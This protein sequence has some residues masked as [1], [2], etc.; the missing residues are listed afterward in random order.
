[1]LLGCVADD[2]TGASDLANALVKGGM[3]SIQFVGVPSGEAP[4]DC[5]AGII[6]LK[7]RSAPRAEAVEKSLAALEWL[8][9]QGC[10]QFL[11]KYCSTFDSTPAGN[12]GPVAAALRNALN[13][14]AV[15]FCPAFPPTGRTVYMGH[16]FVGDTLINR[17]GMENHPLNPMT[18]SDIR[19]W[20]PCRLT[21]AWGSRH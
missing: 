21:S 5:E 1:M 14:G 4:S 20:S 19:R 7:T 9:R 18:E 12:I 2:F 8:R 17:S 10:R 13:A 3:A 6:A 15:V 11:F 16:L